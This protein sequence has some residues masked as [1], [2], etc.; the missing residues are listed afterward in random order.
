ML[1]TVKED[2]KENYNCICKS[3]PNGVPFCTAM[4]IPR[5]SQ[6]ERRLRAKRNKNWL[7]NEFYINNII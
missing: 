2:H 3:F 7:I 6:I 5:K 1:C 4:V